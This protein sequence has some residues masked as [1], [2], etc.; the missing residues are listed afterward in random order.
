MIIQHFKNIEKKIVN[1]MLMDWHD[2]EHF[3]FAQYFFVR[4]RLTLG[5]NLSL[6]IGKE[7]AREGMATKV[8]QKRCG[9]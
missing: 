5:I 3:I 9:G 6:L 1:F 8:V 7:T 4:D 2:F